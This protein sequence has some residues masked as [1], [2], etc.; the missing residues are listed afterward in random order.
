MCLHIVSAILYTRLMLNI[1]WVS[2]LRYTERNDPLEAKGISFGS[3]FLT[4]SNFN[5]KY[6]NGPI[7]QKRK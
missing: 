1:P 6:M 4:M 5:S 3:L 7:D 2:M